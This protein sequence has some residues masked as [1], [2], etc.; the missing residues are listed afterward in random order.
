MKIAVSASSRGMDGD[1]DPRFGRSPYIL[2]IDT[3]T[4]AFEALEN[5]YGEASSGAGIQVAQFVALKGA[6]AV[7]TGSCGPNATQTLTASGIGIITGVSG[8]IRAAVEE[9]SAGSRSD[10]A[11]ESERPP[12]SGAGTGSSASPCG[13]GSG[14]GRGMGQGTGRGMGRGGGRG[15]RGGSS[16]PGRD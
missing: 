7:L 3:E 9:F 4:M 15:R 11:R 6:R 13:P 16:G 1:V 5:P 14:R 8:P 10:R 2:I 12:L